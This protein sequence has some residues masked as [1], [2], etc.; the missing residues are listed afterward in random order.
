MSLSLNPLDVMFT[1]QVMSYDVVNMPPV[2]LI[3][4]VQSQGQY[5][6]FEDIKNLKI[7]VRMEYRFQG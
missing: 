1:N 3:E 6:Q 5:Y 2:S 4:N 7:P